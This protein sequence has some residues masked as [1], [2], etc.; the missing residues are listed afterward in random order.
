MNAH[1]STLPVVCRQLKVLE[2]AI[3]SQRRT[4][5]SLEACRLDTTASRA[6]LTQ[7]LEQLDRVLSAGEVEPHDAVM[8]A[9]EREPA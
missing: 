1:V 9:G 3:A 8:T 7:L 2:E 4:I 5:A 6:C